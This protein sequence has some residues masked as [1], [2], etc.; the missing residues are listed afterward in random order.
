MSC[1]WRP[2]VDRTFWRCNSKRGRCL[3]IRT[4]GPASAQ[5]LPSSWFLSRPKSSHSNCLVRGQSLRRIAEF[6]D[7]VARLD[8]Q[9]SSRWIPSSRQS[10]H[11][12]VNEL[13]HHPWQ[14]RLHSGPKNQ[15]GFL[16]IGVPTAEPTRFVTLCQSRGGLRHSTDRTLWKTKSSPR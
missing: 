15:D 9:H 13:V 12:S 4:S 8:R 2:S 5:R 1:T 7:W 6:H 14:V 16:V 11:L 3:T 10:Q